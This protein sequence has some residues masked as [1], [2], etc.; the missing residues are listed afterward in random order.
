MPN[1]KVIKHASKSN[2]QINVE[3]GHG[4]E[5]ELNEI[6]DSKLREEEENEKGGNDDEISGEFCENCDCEKPNKNDAADTHGHGGCGSDDCCQ[7]PA[8]KSN[9]NN[10]TTA[11]SVETK[12]S[13]T[14]DT[15]SVDRVS[16]DNNYY[17]APMTSYV[18]STVKMSVLAL[19]LA[20]VV[21]FYLA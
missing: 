11:S 3:Y 7:A 12:K 4:Q 10:T 1:G 18:T 5:E 13:T 9:N 16:A 14:S 2:K 20:V 19:V 21:M 17:S 15:A 8:T 6:D